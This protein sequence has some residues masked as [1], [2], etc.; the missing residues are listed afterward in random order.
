MAAVAVTDG[1]VHYGRVGG[2]QSGQLGTG[3]KGS[4]THTLHMSGEGETAHHQGH[5]H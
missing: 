5:V 2:S 3:G 1:P 4:N